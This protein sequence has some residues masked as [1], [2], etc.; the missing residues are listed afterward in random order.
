MSRLCRLA[1]L[2]LLGAPPLWS[3]TIEVPVYPVPED[4]AFD[5][6]L[7]ATKLF[8]EAR[9]WDDA[10]GRLDTLD[11][12]AAELIVLDAAAVLETFREGLDKECLIPGGVD[13]STPFPYLADLRSLARLLMVES[14]ARME[15][16]DAEQAFSSCL[17]ALKL[18]RDVARG[19]P[20][21]HKL[22]SV[23]C[24]S[25][26][27]K[28]IRAMAPMAGAP[29]ALEELLARLQ[30]V[31]AREIPLSVTLA[32]EWDATRRQLQGWRDDPEQ[33]TQAG[34][35]LGVPVLQIN[36]VVLDEALARLE[37]YY[38]QMIDVAGTDYW[39]RRPEDV[40]PPKGN[41]LVEMIVPVV[42]RGREKEVRHLAA[43]RATVLT[44][45]LEL[46]F[47]RQ[48]AYPK[49]LA[50]LTPDVLTELPVD[51]FSGEP[52]RYRREGE[53]TYTLYSVGP[54]GVDDGGTAGPGGEALDL[55]FSAVE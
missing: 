12:A 39:L 6:Y 10:A 18:G 27:L 30:E 42:G 31:E 37:D 5:H 14:H 46:H 23:A 32:V 22:V 34:A 54:N 50:E 4:N 26:A 38:A 33:R 20:L 29:E 45:A 51:P 41:V 9:P 43:L 3:A 7:R 44:V 11:P 47:A 55:V 52:F 21:I 13:F 19:G 16:G 15:Q 17:D 48:G 8:P 2:F 24:E 53:L 40:P 25:I 1:S 35:L 49:A 28:R 36:D